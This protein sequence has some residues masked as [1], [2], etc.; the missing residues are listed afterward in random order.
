MRRQ[1]TVEYTADEYSLRRDVQFDDGR[2]YAHRCE[3]KV[4]EAVALHFEDGHGHTLEEIARALSLPYT[5]VNVA[6]EFMKD[7]GVI[8]VRY[9]R[10]SYAASRCVFE[11]AMIEYLAK[12]AQNDN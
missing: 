8:E 2:G 5:Q 11:D 7:R 3:R 12:V 9:K 4:Y 1:R 10:T 6:M